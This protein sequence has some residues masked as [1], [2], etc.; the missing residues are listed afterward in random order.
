MLLFK[1]G[2]EMLK[3]RPHALSSLRAQIILTLTLV[4]LG[5]D[6]FVLA[7]FLFIAHLQ[8]SQ[9]LLLSVL[10]TIL[11][12]I[13]AITV[14]QV[15]LRILSRPLNLIIAIM[16]QASKGDLPSI[17]PMIERYGTRGD[18]GA[19]LQTINALLQRTHTVIGKM[20]LLSQQIN[21]ILSIYQVFATQTNAAID[22]IT[23]SITEVA[24]GAREQR[25][26]L[27]DV[28][29]LTN[30][31]A[32]NSTLTSQHA[33]TTHEAMDDLHMRI[34]LTGKRI[35]Q[36]EARSEHIGTIVATIEGLADQTN[37]LALNAA[38]EAAR[39]GVHGREFAIVA[40]EVRKLAE[41]SS[42]AAQEI[43]Q[44]VLQ[45]QEEARETTAA[46]QDVSQ[47]IDESAA[48][49]TQTQHAATLM[50]D[51][52]ERASKDITNIMTISDD[53]STLTEH[54]VESIQ[55]LTMRM[56]KMDMLIHGLHEIAGELHEAAYAFHWSYHDPWTEDQ[57]ASLRSHQRADIIQKILSTLQSHTVWKDTLRHMLDD[58]LAPTIANETQCDFSQWLS[59]EG[60]KML[61]ADLYNE[62]CKCH[63]EFHRVASE[64]INQYQ[65]GTVA[66]AE[67]S[68]LLEGDFSRA[69]EMFFEKLLAAQHEMMSENAAA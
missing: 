38:I 5:F 63:S 57:K 55:Q 48:R 10:M 47:T 58:N 44:M 42:Q 39:A 46:M 1:D 11:S 14:T 8:S 60:K 49:I 35:H 66:Q 28:A 45:T 2:K 12:A 23:C 32:S 43:S 18:V 17:T 67:Q 30:S 52:T 54:V 53:H 9:L 22:Q 40:D 68:L 31:L 37:L 41:R 13:A 56:T 27:M 24:Q 4:C 20:T 62:I 34:D 36:L 65:Q 3:I 69:D 7:I 50:K 59:Q 6:L 19:S 61:P 29:S 21:T 16:R 26:H 15:M 25:E 33:H 64:V 51:S